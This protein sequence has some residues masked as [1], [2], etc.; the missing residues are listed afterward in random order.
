MLK[1]CDECWN[2]SHRVQR[3][4]GN[5][6]VIQ[7]R[8]FK[9]RP[10]TRSV[11]APPSSFDPI[12]ACSCFQERNTLWHSTLKLYLISML[13]CYLGSVLIESHTVPEM[14]WFAFVT[15]SAHG[16]TV[17]SA[18]LNRSWGYFWRYF[19]VRW[20]CSPLRDDS[21][22]QIS[23]LVDPHLQWQLS[24]RLSIK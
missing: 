15:L 13:P 23:E 1:S 24:Y 9:F 20:C 8:T 2:A 6:S 21:L 4:M 10:R 3:D 18:V 12:T 7:P 17:G 22:G 14:C 5:P 16:G 11:S 19:D